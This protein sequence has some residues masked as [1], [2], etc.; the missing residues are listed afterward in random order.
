MKK[1]QILIFLLLLIADL[2]VVYLDL[3]AGEVFCKPL[4][5]IWLLAC[6]ALQT[7]TLHS[8]LKK[9]FILALVFSWLGDVLLLFVRDH[10]MF[11]LLGLSA[12]LVAH[13]FY[14][15]FF[16]FVRVRERIKSRWWLVLPVAVYYGLLIA[17]LNPYLGDMLLPVRIYGIVISFMLMLALHMTYI[18]NRQAG[19]LMLLG[20][21]LFVLSDSILAINKFY[22]PFKSA[23]LFIMLTYGLAQLFLT[24]GAIH[25]LISAADGREE[26]NAGSV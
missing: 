6:F 1:S 7:R 5:C 12:F 16:H 11:F 4:L 14:I 24:I 19:M 9:W 26:S 21:V 2:T 3:E 25:Y 22:Q 20:A 23:G 18:K 15:L 8:D 10:S 13:I 17:L